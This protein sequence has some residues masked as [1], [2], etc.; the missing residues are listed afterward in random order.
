[1][2]A[3]D[4]GRLGGMEAEHDPEACRRDVGALEVRDHAPD[5][6][7]H[8]PVSHHRAHRVDA[9][10]VVVGLVDDVGRLR[11]LAPPVRGRTGDRGVPVH[12]QR[13]MPA[14]CRQTLYEREHIGAVLGGRR[15]PRR[16]CLGPEQLVERDPRRAA[17]GG[18][19]GLRQQLGR[20]GRNRGGIG[21]VGRVADD[22][23]EVEDKVRG[24]RPLAPVVGGY[25][26]PARRHHDPGMRQ[27]RADI[28]P[29]RAFAVVDPE[30]RVGRQPARPERAVRRRCDHS[31]HEGDAEQGEEPCQGRAR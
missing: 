28:R 21:G 19:L 11:D 25:S 22:P 23:V 20:S 12:Q 15:S 2:P 1:M 5:S 14:A 16:R 17:V 18:L 30:R 8:A 26:R 24:R 13:R 10:G 3:G 7:A 4:A 27:D 31:R 9:R 29:H 6:Q